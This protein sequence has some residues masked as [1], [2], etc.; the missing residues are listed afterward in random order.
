MI[1]D[2]QS[3]CVTRRLRTV[4]QNKPATLFLKY[5]APEDTYGAQSRIAVRP[6][7]AQALRIALGFPELHQ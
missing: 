1:T 4:T 7:S 3:V 5:R 2:K 6:V